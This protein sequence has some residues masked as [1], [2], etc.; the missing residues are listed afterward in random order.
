MP[1]NSAPPVMRWTMDII[2]VSSGLEICGGGGGGRFLS[3]VDWASAIRRTPSGN[4]VRFGIVRIRRRC[5]PQRRY[6]LTSMADRQT[7]FARNA[8]CKTKDGIILNPI[9]FAILVVFLRKG[10]SHYAL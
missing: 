5:P 9:Q 8:S 3:L 10:R 6:P 2:I 7:S 1:K 4:S